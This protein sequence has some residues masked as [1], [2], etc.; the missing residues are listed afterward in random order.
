MAVTESI[1]VLS[2]VEQDWGTGTRNPS[3][4]KSEEALCERKRRKPGF[5]RKVQTRQAARYVK[6]CNEQQEFDPS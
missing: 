3:S 5:N 4:C 2:K 6:N 1:W